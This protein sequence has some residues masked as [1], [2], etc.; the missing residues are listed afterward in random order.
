MFRFLW[1]GKLEKLKLD[2][3][4]NPSSAGGLNLPC[5]LSKADCLFLSQTCRM[6]AQTN[7]NSKSKSK[8]DIFTDPGIPYPTKAILYHGEL[9]YRYVFKFYY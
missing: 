4:K 5:V 3:I 2:E 9:N 6:L 1:I 7:T 8:Q